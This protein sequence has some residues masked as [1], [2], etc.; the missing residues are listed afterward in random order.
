MLGSLKTKINETYEGSLKLLLSSL[1]NRKN[2]YMYTPE[3]DNQAIVQDRILS[4]LDSIIRFFERKKFEVFKENA[5]KKSKVDYT[6]LISV[7]YK[8]YKIPPL[9]RM[10]IE[11]LAYQIKPEHV[12]FCLNQFK[13]QINSDTQVMDIPLILKQTVKK[14]L[15]D[16]EKER[17]Q[18]QLARGSLLRRMRSDPRV[19]PSLTELQDMKEGVVISNSIAITVTFNSGL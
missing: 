7:P 12:G 11:T 17:Y 1:M 5:R 16:Y 13:N 10:E 3:V 14:R 9:E 2:A 18:T 8:P 19:C 15:G 4:E 6:W